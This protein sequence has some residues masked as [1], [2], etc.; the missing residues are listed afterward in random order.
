M[1]SIDLS[2][3]RAIHI[4]LNEFVI[5]RMKENATIGDYMNLVS[6][7]TRVCGGRFVIIEHGTDIMS[8]D[9]PVHVETRIEYRHDILDRLFGRIFKRGGRK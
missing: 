5:V 6:E 1:D 8:V 7:A 9:I 2:G 3:D 4:G